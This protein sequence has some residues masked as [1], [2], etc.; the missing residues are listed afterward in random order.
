MIKISIID[1]NFVVEKIRDSILQTKLSTIY[2]KDIE[3]F[4]INK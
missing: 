3:Y 1:S 2:G 4:S